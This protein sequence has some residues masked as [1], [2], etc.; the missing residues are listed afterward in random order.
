MYLDRLFSLDPED[1]EKARAEKKASE[2]KIRAEFNMTVEEF[3]EYALKKLEQGTRDWEIGKQ[4]LLDGNE[5]I[6][7][8]TKRL[9]E[10]NEKIKAGRVKLNF[11]VLGI[12]GLTISLVIIQLD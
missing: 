8:G 11:V 3:F 6:A 9:K 4:M 12:L 2:E 1:I 10:A 5:K 7:N